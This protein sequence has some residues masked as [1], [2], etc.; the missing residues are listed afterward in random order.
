MFFV[1]DL[2]INSL[3][4]SSNSVVRNFI[5]DILSYGAIPLINKPTRITKKSVTCLDHIYINS[6]GNQ[7]LLSGIIKTDLSDHLPVFVV[8]SNINANNCP[9][10][11]TKKIRIINEIRTQQ[12]NNALRNINWDFVTCLSCPDQAYNVFLR[13][14]LQLYNLH[15]PIKEI[16]IKRKILLSPW[17][18]KGIK[19]SSKNKQKL[20]IRYLK[21]RT[22]VNETKY[23][24][25][26]NLFERIKNASKKKTFHLFTK[27]ISK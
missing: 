10:K 18:T 6:L 12:F 27:K 20:Y 7:K 2:N 14:L 13:K 8:D 9:E 4:Y 22:F 16:Q 15:F 25:Y 3:D 23:K 11:I 24:N 1:G 5:N 17:I 21:S 19:K 26:K